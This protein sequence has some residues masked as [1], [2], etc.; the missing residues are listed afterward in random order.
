MGNTNPKISVIVPVYKVEKYLRK[1]VDSLLAQTFEDFEVI[2][3]DDGSPDYSG[4]I[5]DEYVTRDRRVRVIHQQNGGVSV[6]RQAGMDI[7]RGEYTIHVDPDDWVEPT[8]LSSLYAKAKEEE[9][10]MV[11][12]D[13]YMNSPCQQ[14]YIRQKPSNLNHETIL[15]E[16][17]QHLHGSCCNKLI[18]RVCYNKYG[19]KFPINISRGEDFCV[20]CSL[21][22]YPLKIS[23]LPK[24]FYHYVKNKNSITHTYTQKSV[25]DQILRVNYLEKI[26]DEERYDS[27]LY[28]IK[29]STLIMSFCI[30]PFDSQ[31]FMEIVG[32]LD[33]KEQFIKKNRSAPFY[34][35]RYQ[36]GRYIDGHT[37]MPRLYLCM[38]N[39]L[40]V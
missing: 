17:F 30:R 2:L 26:L 4:N 8:M 7:A 15:R 14:A 18:R 31:K 9:A 24:A 23:Y 13:F 16:L 38:K 21:L 20:V 33:I 29:E 40:K 22:L 27:E 1:C 11:I 10:D 5:C 6:A 37:V 12:C 39:V 28:S 3:V 35:L 25:D 34:T 19:V 36:V 32:R